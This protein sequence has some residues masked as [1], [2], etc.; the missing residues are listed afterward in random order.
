MKINHNI[1]AMITQGALHSVN[2]AMSKSL[3][4]LSTGLRINTAADDAAGL[5]VSENLRTQV[6]GMGQ[7]LKNTQDAVSMLNIADGALNE[8]ASIMQRMRELVIQAKNDTYTSTERGY[9]GTEF[10]S[11]MKELD[12][13]AASTNFNGMKIFAAPEMNNNVQV[14]SRLYNSASSANTA[15]ESVD[16][17]TAWDDPN[18]SV[19]GAMDLASSNHFNFFVGA[20]YTDTDAAAYNAVPESFDKNASDMITVQFGQMD[21][22]ALLS[23]YPGGQ[24]GGNQFGGGAEKT[25]GNFFWDSG[26]PIVAHDREDTLIDG[27]TDGTIG[28][29]SVQ[30]KLSLLLNILDGGQNVSA[31]LKAQGYI[32]SNAVWNTSGLSRINEMRAK[33]GAMTN[34]LEHSINNTMNQVNNTQAAESLVRDVDFASETANFTKNQILTQSATAML[35]QANSLPQSV[36]KLIS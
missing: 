32:A 23:L 36:L 14:N 25:F 12:R 31:G 30:N 10:D 9:M 28:N 16:A 20:N 29:G 13:I 1:S 6:T 7:A 24:L 8:Q 33:I 5:G 19:F 4:K 21:A 17:R 18:D 2:Q 22:N 3:Q 34:R 15:H 35:A 11:L 26:I 27:F